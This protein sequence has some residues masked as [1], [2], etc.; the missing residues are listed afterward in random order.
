LGGGRESGSGWRD[1]RWA[2]C[3]GAGARHCVDLARSHRHHQ[4]CR[5]GSHHCHRP[6]STMPNAMWTSCVCVWGALS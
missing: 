5:Q 1:W 6:F 4:V 2:A 3:S